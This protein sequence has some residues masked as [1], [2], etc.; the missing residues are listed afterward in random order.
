MFEVAKHL[1]D[2][3]KELATEL[4]KSDQQSIPIRTTGFYV[5]VNPDKKTVIH[6]FECENINCYITMGK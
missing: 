3:A 2:D 1:I 6:Q 5:T 4:V